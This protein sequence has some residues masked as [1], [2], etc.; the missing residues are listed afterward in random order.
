MRARALLFLVMA[1]LA[2]C[3][4]PH[5]GAT[6]D[7]TYAVKEYPLPPGAGN[8]GAMTVDG[9]GNVWL[10]QDEPPVLYRLGRENSTFS[11]YTLEGFEE[12]GFTGMTADEVGIVWFAD[13]RGNRFGAYQ[14]AT[15]KTSTFDFPGPMAP[16]SILRRGDS[17]YIGCK[18]EVGEYDLRFPREPLLDHFVYHMDSHLR[19]IHFDRFGNVWAVEYARNNVSVYWRTYDKTSEFAIPTADAYPASLS[20]DSQG[21]LWF[22]ESGTNKLGLFH[23]E[24]FNFSEYEMPS[25]DGKTPVISR[26]T[27]V[28]DAVWLTDMRYDRVLQ[29][30]PEEGRFAAA[31]L[32]DDTRPVFIEPDGNGTLWVYEAGSKTL[33]SLE[34]TDQ[35]GQ[36]TP[37]PTPVPTATVQP[38]PPPS[39]VPSGTPG[40]AVLLTATALALSAIIGRLRR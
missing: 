33:A 36:A 35:F 17:V 38:C 28:G 6:S 12:A 23:T 3:I 1:G 31:Q 34:V 20:I 24:L 32:A 2:F 39:P 9:S 29:F 15:N 19:D 21:R 16:T 40:L 26:V 13:P 7:G 25:V 8:I 27:T 18:E 30:Y 4:L 10:I 22:V 37:T 11:N 5:A 14:E